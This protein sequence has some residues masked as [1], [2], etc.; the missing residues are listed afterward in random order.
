MSDFR[1]MLEGYRLVTAEILYGLPDHPKLLQSYIWQ[2]YDLEPKFPVLSRF[3][4]FWEKNL[5]G[6]LHSVRIGT[7]R[8]ITPAEIA[9]AAHYGQLN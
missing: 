3:L 5:E 1:L 7:R 4:A 8:V 2:D 9:H 6:P